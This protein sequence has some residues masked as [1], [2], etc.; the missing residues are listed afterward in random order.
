MN[1]HQLKK[2]VIDDIEACEIEPSMQEE[3]LDLFE[4]T[5]KSLTGTLARQ[6]Q[7][8]TSDYASAHA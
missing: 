6:A 3:L 4:S 8:D 5:M 2:A 1:R 7:F